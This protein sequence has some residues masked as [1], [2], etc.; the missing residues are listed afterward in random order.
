MPGQ[1]GIGTLTPRAGLQREPW[2]CS[3][4]QQGLMGT[5]FWEEPGPG[6]YP[7][8]RFGMLGGAGLRFRLILVSV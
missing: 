1:P 8:W 3:L 2:G 6:L 7:Y 4:L 5:V